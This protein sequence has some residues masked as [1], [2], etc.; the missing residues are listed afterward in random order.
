MLE[1]FDSWV[2]ELGQLGYFAIALAALIEYLAPPFPGDTIVLMGGAY[3]ARGENSVLLV[4]LAVT[5]A[6]VLGISA[7][8]AVGSY[9]AE[10]VKARPEGHLLFGVT[11]ARVRELQ[12][13][14]RDHGAWLLVVNRFLPT[15]R[16]VLFIAAGASHMPLRKVLTL[17][18]LSALAWNGLLLAVGYLVGGNAE[19]LE[20]L[21]TEYK[22]GASIVLGLVVV[23]LLVRWWLRREKKEAQSR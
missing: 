8:Y 19:R 22:R 3:A 1:T 13:K 7:N 20:R 12:E 9:V 4:W 2:R 14:M 10:R 15:F 23:A 17:G 18:V 21:L 6:S 11:H 5:V 16:T